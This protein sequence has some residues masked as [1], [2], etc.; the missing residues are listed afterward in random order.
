MGCESD[1]DTEGNIERQRLFKKI[2]IF[3]ESAAGEGQREGDSGSEAGS[4]WIG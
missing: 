4:A 2:F 1:L 3:W